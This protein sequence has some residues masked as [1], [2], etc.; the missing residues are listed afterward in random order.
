[1]LSNNKATGEKILKFS[2]W[3]MFVYLN[4]LHT[5]LTTKSYISCII[6][7]YVI[8]FIYR[9]NYFDPK[10]FPGLHISLLLHIKHSFVTVKM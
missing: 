1:M 6:F 7:V 9:E 5:I 4:W 3:F 2:L 10:S 8:H